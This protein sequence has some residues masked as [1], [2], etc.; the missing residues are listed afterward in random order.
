MPEFDDFQAEYGLVPRTRDQLLEYPANFRWELTRRHPYYLALWELTAKY[1]RGELGADREELMDG[2]CAM[3]LLRMIG[4]SGTP[5]DPSKSFAELGEP[6]MGSGTIQPMT[7][8]AITIA[9][10][11]AL[12]PADLRALGA[13]MMLAGDPEYAMPHDDDLSLQRHKAQLEL[14][15]MPSQAFD[16]YLSSPL[17]YI[18]LGASQRRIV[19]DLEIHVRSW[20]EKRGI[21]ERRL[22]KQQYA[23]YLDVWD[24]HEGWS[25]G[26]YSIRHEQ[27][28]HAIGRQLQLH[29]STAATQYRAAFRLIVGVEFT[30]T[31]WFQLVAMHKIRSLVDSPSSDLTA[32]YRRILTSN[33]KKPVPESIVT[34]Q[35]ID[36]GGGIVS[37]ESTVPSGQ[38]DRELCLDLA[39][40]VGQGLPDDEIIR[41]L[42]L[43]T[44][45]DISYFRRRFQDFNEATT[46]ISEE[47]E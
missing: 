5:E 17:Y 13:I 22:R 10:I 2:Y 41:K 14:V 45:F 38:R 1:L 19:E 25:N 33:T 42:E 46:G 36:V 27:T 35:S 29:Q 6:L 16:A 23:E 39:E 24:A 21:A 20:K 12:P 4:V 44:D 34:P 31:N 30:P 28:F 32:R 47:A 7:I 18:H 40:L 26:S 8:R 11:D 43:P 9:L 37:H 15:R 3:H